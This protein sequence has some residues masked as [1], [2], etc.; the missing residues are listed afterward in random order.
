MIKLLEALP[1]MKP[2]EAAERKKTGWHDYFEV[3]ELLK[4]VPDITPGEAAEW[5]LG[6]RLVM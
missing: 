5:K 1:E 2:G 6:G 3:I 4:A